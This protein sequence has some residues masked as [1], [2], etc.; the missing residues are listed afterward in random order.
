MSVANTASSTGF[1]HSFFLSAKNDWETGREQKGASGSWQREEFER[2]ERWEGEKEREKSLRV[3]S[4]PNGSLHPSSLVNCYTFYFCAGD[5]GR[6]SMLG[7]YTLCSMRVS[8]YWRKFLHIGCFDIW[9]C[10]VLLAGHTMSESAVFWSS[11]IPNGACSPQIRSTSFVCETVVCSL[12]LQSRFP[13]CK[14]CCCYC[15]L[16][17]KR[18]IHFKC[19]ESEDALMKRSKF[20]IMITSGGNLA[21]LSEIVDKEQ[22]V[23]NAN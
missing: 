15:C 19:D 17:I 11:D 1:S 4:P 16:L 20:L 5:W 18:W 10:V 9:L 6:G 2:R 14:C 8:L 21:A 22:K 23:V 7:T 12:S 13:Q 3:S